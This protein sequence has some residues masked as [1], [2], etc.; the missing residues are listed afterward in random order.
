M[1]LPALTEEDCKVIEGVSLTVQNLA[2]QVE[3]DRFLF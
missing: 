2:T 1:L 3:T